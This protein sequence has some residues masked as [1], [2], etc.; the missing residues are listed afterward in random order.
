ML[1]DNIY[2][3]QLVYSFTFVTYLPSTLKPT[4]LN[5][6]RQHLSGIIKK[7]LLYVLS[8]LFLFTTI[9]PVLAKENMPKDAEYKEYSSKEFLSIVRNAR[10]A[11]TWAILSG[12]IS[13][14]RR[15][16][17]QVNE[18]KIKVGMRFTSSRVLAKV[19]VK[20][21][22]EGLTESY[23]VG[24]PYNGL[25]ASIISSRNKKDHNI[26]LLG[27]FGLRPED[28]T[29]TFLYWK[30]KREL[31]KESIKGFNC[32]V[33]ELANPET[34]EIVK[35]YIS[36]QYFYPIKVVWFKP[37]GKTPYRNMIISSFKTKGNLGAP[38][39]LDLYGPGWRT[40]VDFS[41]IRLG[42]TENGIPKDIFAKNLNS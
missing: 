8:S 3:K 5:T 16:V 6:N 31:K 41:K 1:K 25:S 24:Q 15:K 37:K 32:R 18:A 20:E 19:T 29:M 27:S 40:K 4:I 42:Y 14:K 9:R 35:V 33:L 26:P 38:G 7:Y 10:P 2:I 22:K 11:K 28:L 13:N 39:M 21:K 12:T 17:S 30:L 23:T 34:K 36:S